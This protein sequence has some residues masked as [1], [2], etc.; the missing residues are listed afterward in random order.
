MKIEKIHS[1]LYLAREESSKVGTKA[2]QLWEKV[3]RLL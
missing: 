1:A 3:R 2:L